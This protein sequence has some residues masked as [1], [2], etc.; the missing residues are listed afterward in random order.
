VAYSTYVAHHLCDVDVV[1]MDRNVGRSCRRLI[2]LDVV[3]CWVSLALFR[4]GIVPFVSR[5]TAADGR[6]SIR[7]TYA[8]RELSA[9][10][11]R[12]LA[13]TNATFC[14]S[15][16]PLGLRQIVDISSGAE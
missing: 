13:G 2:L 16:A 9:L 1:R 15:I 6:T 3:R 5:I 10:V 7:R 12:A 8:P 14:H 11:A 4:M